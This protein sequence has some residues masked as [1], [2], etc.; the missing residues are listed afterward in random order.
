MQRHVG[1]ANI[2]F[3]Q[4]AQQLV[5]EVQAGGW[6]RHRARGLCIHGLVTLLV[7][8]VRCVLD[9]WRQRQAAMLFDQF[10]YI[11]RKCQRIELTGPLADHDI[12]RI[13]QPDRRAGRRRLRCPY[14]CMHGT[15]VKHTLDQHFDLA[16][17]FLH[18]EKARLQYT[19]VIEYQQIARLQQVDDVGELAVDA[20]VA[21]NVKKPR[22]TA[23][24]KWQLRNQV[25]RQI[26]IEIG[27]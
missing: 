5:I 11:V 7:E 12:E 14:L 9:I 10:K 27:K 19:C 18:A 15:A 13:G 22:S 21:I 24:G 20:M 2:L 16:A 23:F 4:S 3:T 8:L 26:E 25:L 6:R 17:G 1:K